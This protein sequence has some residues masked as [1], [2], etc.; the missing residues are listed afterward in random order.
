MSLMRTLGA[1]DGFAEGYIEVAN[2]QTILVDSSQDIHI[3][4]TRCI[5]TALDHDFDEVV[6]DALKDPLQNPFY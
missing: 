1:I 2:N 5:V 4:N 6:Y 3:I